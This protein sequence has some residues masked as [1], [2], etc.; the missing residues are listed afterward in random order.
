MDVDF[1]FDTKSKRHRIELNGD[2][3][4]LA[5]FLNIEL[6]ESTDL[7]DSIGKT[8]DQLEHTNEG[9]VHFKEWSL[10]I[11]FEDVKVYH[12]NTILEQELS[13]E[14]HNYADWHYVSQC[15]KGDLLELLDSW[16]TFIEKR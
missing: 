10:D 5:S 7:V 14:L 4:A 2:H 3:Q 1:I 9:S 6:A 16:L 8:I 13:D 15:G 11:D 12:H